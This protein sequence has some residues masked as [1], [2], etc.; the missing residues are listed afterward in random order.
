MLP[1]AELR[2]AV[3]QGLYDTVLRPVSLAAPLEVINAERLAED[4]R[5]L[6]WSHQR[7][8]RGHRL[9]R[10]VDR[11]RS[12]RYPEVLEEQPNTWLKRLQI[13]TARARAL[14]EPVQ[15]L[16]ALQRRGPKGQAGDPGSARFA[17]IRLRE[18]A[19]KAGE[20]VAE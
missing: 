13:A 17:G 8:A 3:A 4:H 15:V 5:D 7:P 14:G 20:R 19:D 9:V 2:H 1:V 11:D 10:T 12:H 18:P 16:P 6:L